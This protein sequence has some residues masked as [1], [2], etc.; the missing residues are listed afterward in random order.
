MRSRES[1]E[2]DELDEPQE[3]LASVFQE[4][5]TIVARL[6]TGVV[7]EET[8]FRRRVV[9]L[10]RAAQENARRCGYS[11]AAGKSCVMA[12][13]AFLDESVLNSTGSS[14]EQ[15]RG[16]PLQEELYGHSLLGEKFFDNLRRLL[17]QEDGDEL[18]DVL[19]VYYLC[20]LLGF[21]GR[22]AVSS[23]RDLNE[24]L[25][26]VEKRLSRLRPATMTNIVGPI[27]SMRGEAG[28]RRSTPRLLALA[29]VA[30]LAASFR[31]SLYSSATTIDSLVAESELN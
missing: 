10:L 22:Y 23:D 7:S 14:F 21:R 24:E 18:A 8:S 29:A 12:I 4:C 11:D 28:R 2:L 25:H 20:L 3:N 1:V 30:V 26:K 15:W 5:F 16:K 19:E 17:A 6:R 27:G 31:Y 13:V 9:E